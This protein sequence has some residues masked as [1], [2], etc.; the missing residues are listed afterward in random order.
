MTRLLIVD[1]S[2]DQQDTYEML[3]ESEG[4]DIV[5]AADGAAGL[6]AVRALRPDVVLLD[7]MM[8]DVD[9]LQFLRRLPIECGPRLPPVIAISG[10]AAYRDEALRLGAFAFLSKP[11]EVDVLH[12]AV[13]NAVAAAP[14]PVEVV[15]HNR[16]DVIA[17][18]AR[19]EELRA[20]LVAELTPLALDD[21]RVR[22]RALAEWLQRYYGFGGTFIQL[23]HGGELRIEAARGGLAP[24]VEGH[25][26]PREL[27]WC[28]D[29]IDAGSTLVLCDPGHHPL[30]YFAH[31][32]QAR[33]GI[34][35]YA[36]VPLT[37]WSGAV[38]GTLCMCDLEPHVVHAED[39]RL[40]EA[41]GLHVAHALEEV[42]SGA[43]T[44]DFVIDVAALFAPEMLPLFVHASV[45]R[46]ARTGGVVGVAIVRLADGSDAD[47]AAH[48]A[49]AGTRG[50]GLVITRRGG[51]EIA[52]VEVGHDGDAHDSL[53]AA[54]AACRRA[55]AVSSVGSAWCRLAAGSRELT[56]GVD[57]DL[58]A[59]LIA[60]AAESHD[61]RPHDQS[62]H[63]QHAAA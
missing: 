24:F 56:D 43:D 55:V 9:G 50:P 32:P 52:L 8:P 27:S 49:Y 47:V 59:R 33:G 37:T 30:P 26:Y 63:D 10:F 1:D 62:S 7:M 22:L 15:Q 60:L 51:D 12:S 25:S 61:P 36:G 45:Q 53:A 38:I 17:S 11:M 21:I 14:L 58:C 39:M 40:F 46:A 23:L 54:L 18:R 48:A 3:L 41:L 16:E 44:D 57:S 2:E 29:V 31:H 20:E 5:K 34:R 35:F 19:G 13:R 6:R 28:S 42:A 4:Y